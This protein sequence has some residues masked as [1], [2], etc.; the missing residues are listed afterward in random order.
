MMAVNMSYCRFENTLRALRECAE[1]MSH[2]NGSDWIAD[3]ELSDSEAKAARK[4]VKLC[5]QLSDYDS[6]KDDGQ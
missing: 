1:V 4:L 6:E 2:A 3:L 5:T